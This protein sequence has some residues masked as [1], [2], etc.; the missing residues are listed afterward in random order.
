MIRFIRTKDMDIICMD[1]N[2]YCQIGIQNELGNN[3]LKCRVYQ[4]A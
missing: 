2:A 1:F 3:S 4:L